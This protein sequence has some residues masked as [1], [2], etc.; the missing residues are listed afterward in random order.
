MIDQLE[1]RLVHADPHFKATC[2]LPSNL[3]F[4]LGD[5]EVFKKLQTF[6]SPNSPSFDDILEH[7]A[8]L[9]IDTLNGTNMDLYPNILTLPVTTCSVE[10]S[11]SEIPMPFL[12][13]SNAF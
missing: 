1:T 6:L 2:L 12:L 5:E 8:P 11:F 9:Y 7:G 4:D 3:Q 10:C 13:G